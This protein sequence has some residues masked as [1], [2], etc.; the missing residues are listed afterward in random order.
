MDKRYQV[1]VSSTYADL[2]EERSKVIQTL[3][4]MDCIPAGM[5]LFPAADQEQFEFIKRVIDDCDY[6]LVI[7]GGRYGSLAPEGVS[8]TEK[9]Y[10]YAVQKGL[11]VVAF[12]HEDPDELATKTDADAEARTRLERFRA[13][14]K[15]GRMVKMWRDAADLPGLVALSMLNTMKTYPAVGWV[16]ADSTASAEVLGEINELR[17]RNAALEAEVASAR[18]E[19]EID[20]PDLAPFDARFEVKGTRIR[21]ENGSDVRRWWSGRPTWGEIFSF[22]GPHL[23]TN[24]LAEHQCRNLLTDACMLYSNEWGRDAELH[25]QVFQTIKV[26]LMALNFIE[27]GS[28]PAGQWGEY[29]TIV[30]R[31]T[32]PG[33]RSLFQTMAVRSEANTD[34]A[35]PEPTDVE[36]SKDFDDDIPF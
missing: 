26:Q 27:L 1:F 36:K 28:E 22:V 4:Q 30:W 29:E 6:Y 32:P 19:P 10:D 15:Q 11:K 35:L 33:Q 7:V 20:I 31:L 18:H 14:V 21:K 8:F 3:M 17:K 9:E 5:E 23:L 13:K 2:R 24:S 16:R 34:S 25:E 12:V